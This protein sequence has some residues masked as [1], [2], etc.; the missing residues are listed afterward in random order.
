MRERKKAQLQKKKRKKQASK[1]ASKKI[2]ENSY[3]YNP[4][5][6][7]KRAPY[8]LR[9]NIGKKFSVIK[10]VSVSSQDRATE[11]ISEV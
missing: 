7:A 3:Y 9:I 2:L 11:A 1:Q 8:K 4:C 6:L 10:I 5:H